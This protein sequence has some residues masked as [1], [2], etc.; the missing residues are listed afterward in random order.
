MSQAETV[1]TF[2]TD[3]KQGS[4]RSDLRLRRRQFASFY[5]MRESACFVRAVAKRLVGGVSAA[6]EP[7]GGAT[8]QSKGSSLGIADLKIAFYADRTVVI[9]RNSCGCHSF[10]CIAVSMPT[11]SDGDKQ[12]RGSCGAGL[13]APTP[14]HFVQIS[15]EKT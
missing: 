1:S 3:V 10:S 15:K 14:H 7:D 11:V 5:G 2:E 12:K 8:G 4:P 13:L 6:A 9:D